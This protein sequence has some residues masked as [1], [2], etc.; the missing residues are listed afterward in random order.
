MGHSEERHQIAIHELLRVTI[1]VKEVSQSFVVVD[2][3]VVLRQPI[4]VTGQRGNLESM[5]EA[6]NSSQNERGYE[7]TSERLL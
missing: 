2:S 3:G 6:A 7:C 1:G 4:E 5:D